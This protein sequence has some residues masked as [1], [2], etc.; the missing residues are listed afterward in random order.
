MFQFQNKKISLN[1]ENLAEQLIKARKEK[2]KSLKNIAQILN[3]NIQYLE[4][5]EKAEFHK[6]PEGLYG[7]NFLKEYAL[8]LGLDL[9]ETLEL[10]LSEKKNKTNKKL[11]VQKT[12]KSY[13]FLSIPKLLKNLLIILSIALILIYIGY[14]INNIISEPKLIIYYPEKDIKT[15]EYTVNIQGKTDETAEVQING[16]KILLKNNGNFDMNID[17]KKGI[18]NI[19]I[20]SQKKYSKQN[21][22]TRKIILEPW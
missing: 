9:K 12:T 16:K 1:S 6:L 21:I 7:Q 20:I 3:I 14:Y 13:Y 4:A 17:L 22:I 10:Y 2:N 5:L 11:F 18:N 15:K 19:T 8:Y